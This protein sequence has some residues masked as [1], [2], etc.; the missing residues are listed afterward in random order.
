[1]EVVAYQKTCK[2]TSRK[3]RIIIVSCFAF[4]AVLLLAVRQIVPSGLG[5]MKQ[6]IPYL[7]FSQSTG[8]FASPSGSSRVEVVSND[9]GAAHSGHFPTWVIVRH[10]WGKEVVAKG[11]LKSSQGDVPITWSSERSFTI[12]FSKQRHGDEE[13]SVRVDLP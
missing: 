2:L 7:F 1:M 4:A 10:W 12:V 8:M 13:D 11:Y 6:I 3:K 9:A 5:G